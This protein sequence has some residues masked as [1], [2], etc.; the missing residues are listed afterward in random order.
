MFPLNLIISDSFAFLVSDVAELMWRSL[1]PF[2][3]THET[4]NFSDGCLFVSSLFWIFLTEK[5]DTFYQSWLL[6]I[7]FL[8]YN[9]QK[10]LGMRIFPKITLI[11]K[12]R[13]VKVTS[14]TFLFREVE[15]LAVYQL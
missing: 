3:M 5:L 1:F 12:K 10:R 8:L 14:T 15:Q 6:T 4:F 11:A 2:W 9:K 13:Q 7:I